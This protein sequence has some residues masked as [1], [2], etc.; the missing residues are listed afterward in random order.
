MWQKHL[1]APTNSVHPWEGG[2]W[3]KL[4]SLQQD[5]KSAA[6]GAKSAGEPEKAQMWHLEIHIICDLPSLSGFSW[7]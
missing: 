6:A 5:S 3:A 2:P 7:W 1:S 4:P